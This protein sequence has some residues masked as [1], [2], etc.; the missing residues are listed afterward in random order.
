MM[1]DID[2]EIVTKQIAELSEEKRKLEETV[3]SAEEARAEE[4]PSITID[5]TIEALKNITLDEIGSMERITAG[6]NEAQIN[7][8]L[9][10]LIDKI[11]L[12]RDTIDIHWNF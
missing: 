3:R 8:I 9:H 2:F 6:G 7:E 12:T 4:E 5:E 11:V 10:I 1:K